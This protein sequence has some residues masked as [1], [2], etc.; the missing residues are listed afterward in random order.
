MASLETA[1][2]GERA[3]VKRQ[4]RQDDAWTRLGY[5]MERPGHA[6]SADSSAPAEIQIEIL[7]VAKG[8]KTT[9]H[10]QLVNT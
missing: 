2:D 3:V 9:M 8:A 7:R 6:C 4:L 5:P 10:A 1:S